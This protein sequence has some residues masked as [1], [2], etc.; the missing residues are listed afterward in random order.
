MTSQKYNERQ[1]KTDEGDWK[2]KQN[3]YKFFEKWLKV[4]QNSRWVK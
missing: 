3:F 1:L 4:K 2:R